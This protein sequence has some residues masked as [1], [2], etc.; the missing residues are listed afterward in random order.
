[1]DNSPPG[2]SI[3]WIFQARILEWVAI[4]LSIN[5]ATKIPK[6]FRAKP[7]PADKTIRE[8]LYK[9]PL[10]PC[11]KK[12]SPFSWQIKLSFVKTIFKL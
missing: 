10:P 11:K 9:T 8:F 7:A 6:F 3:H 5:Q 12:I 1:M 4:S 2:S